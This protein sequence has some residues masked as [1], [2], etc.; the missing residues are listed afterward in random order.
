MCVSGMTNM[1]AHVSHGMLD[2]FTCVIDY[3]ESK[4]NQVAIVYVSIFNSSRTDSIT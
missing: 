4:E 3:C 1:S 2:A